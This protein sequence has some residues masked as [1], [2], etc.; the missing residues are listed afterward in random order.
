MNQVLRRLMGMGRPVKMT[1]YNGVPVHVIQRRP[2]ATA[3][4]DFI[5]AVIR[6][7]RAT[8]RMADLQSDL[9]VYGPHI[10]PARIK[11]TARQHKKA[12]RALQRF[13]SGH[14]GYEPSPVCPVH[15]RHMAF[16]GHEWHGAYKRKVATWACKERGCVQ[17]IHKP[18][19]KSPR[20]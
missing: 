15:H 4:A 6:E 20:G 19:A 11:H 7:D 5:R 10:H 2:P 1:R 14:F 12:R 8:E 16:V 17:K 13:I 9:A 3:L 18:A